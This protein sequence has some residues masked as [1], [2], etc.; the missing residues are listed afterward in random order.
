MGRC[1]DQGAGRRPAPWLRQSCADLADGSLSVR[2]SVD[3]PLRK[4]TAVGDERKRALERPINRLTAAPA[5]SRTPPPSARTA[6]GA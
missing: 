5:E 1:G 2:S 3:A 6:G 4:L